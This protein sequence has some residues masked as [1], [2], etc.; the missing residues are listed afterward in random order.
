MGVPTGVLPTSLYHWMTAV[1]WWDRP[2]WAISALLLGLLAATYVHTGKGGGSADGTGRSLGG[3]VLA[4]FAI[5]CP[6]CNKLVVALIGI[7]G[8][9]NYWA[10]LQPFL[11]LVSLALLGVSLAFRLRQPAACKLAPAAAG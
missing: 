4:T 3:S 11:G 5:G 6:I 2:I 8:A 7:S 10:P 1:T 9:L